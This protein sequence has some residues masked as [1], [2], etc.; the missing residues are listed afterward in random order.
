M[1]TAIEAWPALPLAEWKPTYET[2]HRYTQIVGKVRLALSPML[3]HYWHVALYVT[4][5]GLTTSPIPYGDRTFEVD[6]DFLAHELRIQT[7]DGE[8]HERELGSQSVADF[9]RELLATLHGLGIEVRLSDRVCEIPDATESLSDDRV[10][11]TYDPQAVRRWFQVL[12]QADALLKEFRARFTG[13]VSPVHFFWGSFDLAV[14]RFAGRRAPERRGADAVTRESYCEEVISAGFW[15]G[16]GPFPE[17]AFYAYAAPAPDGLAQAPVRPPEAHYNASFGEFL[18]PYEAVRTSADPRR[19]VFDFLES[20]Y[21]AAADRAGWDRQAL[22]RPL[23]RPVAVGQ[24]A[25]EQP[26]DE[27]P[28]PS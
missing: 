1:S 6:F 24:V 2:L 12:V 25:A 3:N 5:R 20:T 22:E 11:R 27:V 14:T 21:A 18:L 19:T 9:Y 28:A 23:I 8:R 4:S 26:T 17:A 15:P 7:S 16:G 10:H 13:K